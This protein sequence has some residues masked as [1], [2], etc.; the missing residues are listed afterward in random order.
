MSFD[1]DDLWVDAIQGLNHVPPKQKRRIYRIAIVGAVGFS[2]LIDT[3]LLI[4][5]SSTGT[6]HSIAPLVYGAAGLG[7]VAIFSTLHWSGFSERFANRQMTAWQMAYAVGAQLLGITFAPEI[8]TFFLG[9]LFII[10]AFGSLRISFHHA[11]VIWF[12]SCIA[13]SITLALNHNVKITLSHP[14][15]AEDLLISIS[16][17]L[18]LLRTIA[19][20][21]YGSLIRK[22]LYERGLSFEQQATHDPLTGI[23]NRR[24]L[25]STIDEQIS[26]YRR[27]AIPACLAML[28]IDRFKSINDI[29]GHAIGDSILKSLAEAMHMTVRESDKLVRYGG[30]EFVMVLA[31]TDMHEA[32]LLMERICQEIAQHSWP[33][34]P[35]ERRITVSIGLTE[36]L[37]RDQ[38]SDPIARADQALYLAKRSGRNRVVTT[39]SPI[40]DALDSE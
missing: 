15:K 33:A 40:P 3:L 27:K 11:L 38:A 21:Y 14:S 20:G 29:Y 6:I 24:M 19:L 34:L 17:A 7:H 23:L 37:P 28:D 16:F 22:K 35:A 30:E 8:A 39:A 4:I 32:E 12:L 2:Y 10:F 25:I 5:F 1:P 36:I 26:L 13:I 9:I 31:A 18:I